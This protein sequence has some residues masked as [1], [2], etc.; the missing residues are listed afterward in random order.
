[1]IRRVMN[2]S[3]RDGTGIV[4]EQLFGGFGGVGAARAATARVLATPRNP[5]V[6]DSVAHVCS[7][8]YR[9]RLHTTTR[10]DRRQPNIWSL[11]PPHLSQ[12]EAGDP[13]GTGHNHPQS[14][15]TST[16]RGHFSDD[17]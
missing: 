5:V 9:D 3:L 17:I 7:I 13:E 1:M 11:H 8:L 16:A 6:D 2:L 12:N 4:D 14:N 10:S 15:P